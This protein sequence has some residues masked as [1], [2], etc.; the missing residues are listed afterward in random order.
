MSHIDPVRRL[1]SLLA[2]LLFVVSGG[3]SASLAR[4]GDLGAIDFPNTGSA[5]A[6]E[7]FVRG[8]AA[9]HSFWYEEAADLF[10]QAQQIDPD[11]ALAYWGEAM[12]HNRLLWS[13]EDLAA[14]R[15]ALARLAS[16]PEARA[17]K[18]PTQRE[19]D[20]LTTVE[21]LFGPGDRNQRYLGFANAM[22]WLADRHPDDEDAAAFFA[23]TRQLIS[24]PG[25]WQSKQR[26]ESAALLEELYDRHPRH[27]GVLHYM[28]HAYDEPILAPLGLRA[29]HVYAEV[30][31]A[32]PHALH[33]PSH[34]FVQLGLWA[35]AA[36]S[37]EDAYQSSVD[38][39]QRKSLSPMHHDF[40][41]LSWLAYAY[42]QQGRYQA[43]AGTLRQLGDILKLGLA[44]AHSMPGM[45][46]SSGGGAHEMGA[47]QNFH[48]MLARYF[49]ESRLWRSAPA[50]QRFFDLD[51]VGTNA[52]LVLAVGLA[53]VETGDMGR[54]RQTA[55]L[56]GR[57]RQQQEQQKAQE[58]AARAAVMERE[59]RAL[60]DWKAGRTDEALR[61]LGEA[62]QIEFSLP[63]PSGPPHPA[64]PAQELF[65]EVLLALGR[66][67]EAM[68]QYEGALVRTPG[69]VLSLLGSARAA[70]AL[71]DRRT[72]AERYGQLLEAWS[73][74]DPGIEGLEEARTFLRESASP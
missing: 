55:D 37:N 21:V 22:E 56:L 61:Q 45:G 4:Q 38:W 57:L 31:P 26:I 41:S 32:A 27:P 44:P 14:G 63:P 36:S 60:I 49:I 59:V 51:L 7:P 47:E 64:K 19:R 69:R 30:A 70:V 15:A 52:T 58:L 13:F 20:Y 74:A 72:A 28:L 73:Q 53:A 34:I 71:G 16:T 43:A 1:V 65:G 8:L 48:E 40:H 35:A 66:P 23:L 50:G 17:A 46:S 29:A 6:Q 25:I 62:S 68:Q 67:A 9:L 54:A 39:A 5:E 3:G 10:R 42:L 11:F 12:C 18:A 24:R 33:M 2:L